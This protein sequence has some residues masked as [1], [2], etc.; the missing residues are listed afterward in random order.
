MSSR[1]RLLSLSTAVFAGAPI[2]QA[3]AFE[4]LPYEKAAVDKAIRSGAP[5]VVH[6]Y[7]P[8]CLQCRAQALI[9]DQLSGEK[10]F[11]R[12]SFFRVDYD[13]QKSVVDALGVPRSTLIAYKGGKE[14]ARMSWGTAQEDVVRVLRTAL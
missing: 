1:R 7:A 12:I 4:S 6:V 11:N 14:A 2:L 5:V 8:W 10:Q 9:L 13:G 3:G